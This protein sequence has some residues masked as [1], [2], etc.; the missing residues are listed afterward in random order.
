VSSTATATFTEPE[1]L[2]DTVRVALDPVDTWDAPLLARRAGQSDEVR[3]LDRLQPTI[4]T[5]S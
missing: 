5:R 3:L 2:P 4:T 1:P